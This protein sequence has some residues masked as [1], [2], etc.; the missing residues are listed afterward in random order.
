[1][2]LYEPIMLA[3][4]LAERLEELIIATGRLPNGDEVR[5]ELKKFN[6]EESCLDRGL[7]IHRGR[8]IITLTFPRE[9][10]LIIDILSSTGEL[11]DALEVIAY[12]D[13]ELEAYIVEILPANE[14][15]FEGNIGLEPVIIDDKN[16]ELKS[17][18]VLGYFEEH[19]NGIFL[20]IDEKTY[21]RWKT[22]GNTSTCP[23]CGGELAWRG[24][25]AYCRDCGYGVRVVRE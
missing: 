13:R 22:G 6:L 5:E 20:A 8:F 12:H 1:M 17:N 24:N 2:R 19:E 3:L 23:I 25:E 10:H 18:P 21:R 9:E 7:A 15:E 4:P 16:F 14:L 11:S